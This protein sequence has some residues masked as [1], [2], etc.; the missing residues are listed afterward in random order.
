[1]R[2]AG[3]GDWPYP[4]LSGVN[5]KLLT[6]A[7][8]MIQIL[9][10]NVPGGKWLPFPVAGCHGFYAKANGQTE[11]HL[12]LSP[13]ARAGDPIFLLCLAK[14]QTKP[15]EMHTHAFFGKRFFVPVL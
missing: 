7:T 10:G 15:I 11:L 2:L 9:A 4:H 13:E 14:V 12:P 6:L 5:H 1:M 3:V 8:A